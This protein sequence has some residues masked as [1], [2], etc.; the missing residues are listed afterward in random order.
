ME[1]YEPRDER[2]LKRTRQACDS[3]RRKKSKCSGE[4]PVCATCDR[5]RRSCSY[6]LEHHYAFYTE[7]DQPR[8]GS[9]ESRDDRI[10]SLESTLAEVVQGLRN[11]ISP[12]TPSTVRR[13]RRPLAPNSPAPSQSTTTAAT[14]AKQSPLISLV[15]RPVMPSWDV[16]TS[17]AQ[18]YLVYCDSQ[19]LPLFHRETFVSSFVR[20]DSEVVYAVL[21]LASNFSEKFPPSGHDYGIDVKEFADAALQLAMSRVVSR[22]VE[23]ST[24]Q[25]LVLLAFYEL[26]NGDLDQCRVHSSMAM[27]LAQCAQLHRDMPGNKNQQMVDERRR[28]YWSIALLH[29]LLGEQVPTYSDQSTQQIVFPM[30]ASSPP[31]VAASPE[32]QRLAISMRPD[33]EQGILSVVLRLS[34]VWSMVQIYVKGQRS[35]V[36]GLAPWSHKSE[37]SK[38]LSALMDLGQKLPPIHR[39]RFIRLSSITT[40][41]LE[42]SREYWGPWFLSRFLYHTSMCI[43]NHPI[44]IMLQLQGSRDVSEVFLQQTFFSLSHHTSWILHFIEFLDSRQ[45]YVSDPVIGYSAAVAATIE[46]HQSFLEEEQSARNKK[47]Q[48]YDQCLKLILD[49]RHQWP[50][51]EHIA[52]KLQSLAETMSVS[53]ETTITRQSNNICI[54]ISGFFGILDFSAFCSAA[55]PTNIENSMF[56][57][58]L[59]FHPTLQPQNQANLERLPSITAIER[60]ATSTERA[61]A[62]AMVNDPAPQPDTVHESTNS[63]A[64]SDVM[65]MPADQFNELLLPADQFFGGYAHDSWELMLGTSSSVHNPFV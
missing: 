37:Y 47:K 60:T 33:E 42:E 15:A 41:E 36:R 34:E 5:L 39:Y 64:T 28:C 50:H 12:H 51:M 14:G 27:T 32:G 65:L 59:A 61:N 11:G 1:T 54:D 13:Q 18:V 56:G 63:Q 57:S 9:H 6:T 21:V 30:S 3:C 17:M 52:K 45:F 4:R 16:V 40:E 35:P 58:T 20:R 24:L 23:L 25:T 43:L 2:P 55:R 44:L 19:P 26:N 46:L 38:A 62:L 31:A 7:Q 53:Y 49:M 10:E 48:G 22:R 29:R 8:H